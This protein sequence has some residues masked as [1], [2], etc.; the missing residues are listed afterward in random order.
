[1]YNI[2]MEVKVADFR[3]TKKYMIGHDLHELKL[4]G[5]SS[6]DD[7]NAVWVVCD[8]GLYN[9]PKITFE[10]Q[11]RGIDAYV[12]EQGI[13]KFQA[14]PD[15]QALFHSHLKNGGI[16]L[17]ANDDVSKQITT[18]LDHN[19]GTEKYHTDNI[20]QLK[21]RGTLYEDDVNKIRDLLTR[22][23]SVKAKNNI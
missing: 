18:F 5:K 22:N 6:A 13:N 10:L 19:H 4:A 16:I 12:A 17:A 21:V 14:D 9:S 15:T 1:M 7:P 11:Q 2:C 8:L 20:I 3:E 23:N